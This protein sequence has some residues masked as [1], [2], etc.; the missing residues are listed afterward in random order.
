MWWILGG[1]PWRSWRMGKKKGKQKKADFLV[2]F[3]KHPSSTVTNE[4]TL[5][6]VS[7]G[8]TQHIHSGKDYPF[9]YISKGSSTQITSDNTLLKSA[10]VISN[11]SIGT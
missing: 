7:K 9:L 2:I 8:G 5:L 11:T 4:M 1:S 3:M 10:K 6:Y